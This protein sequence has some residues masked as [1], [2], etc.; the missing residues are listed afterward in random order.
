MVDHRDRL[1]TPGQG[2][3]EHPGTLEIVGHISSENVQKDVRGFTTLRGINRHDS[4]LTLAEVASMRCDVH[5]S[6]RASRCNLLNIGNR[7]RSPESETR[8]KPICSDVGGRNNTVEHSNDIRAIPMHS[9][10]QH[11]PINGDASVVECWS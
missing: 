6:N 3:R 11:K 9:I 1:D 2:H 10:K 7:T 4:G 5:L 8:G